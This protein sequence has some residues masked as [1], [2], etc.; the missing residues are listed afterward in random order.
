MIQNKTK[1]IGITGG[2]GTG[3]S[4]V[5]DMIREKGYPVIDADKIARQVVEKGMPA[6][7]MIVKV[8][9]EEILQK[10]GEINRKALGKI[11]FNDEDQR[12]KLNN[13]V[14]SYIYDQIKYLIDKNNYIFDI[15]FLDIPLL[16]EEYDIIREG[17]ILFDE[18]WLVYTDRK[19][20]VQ[21]IIKRD[22]ISEVDAISR[23]DAQI[24]IENKKHMASEI[25]DNSGTRDELGR[26]LDMLFK[27]V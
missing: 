19:T 3:K 4:T 23:I 10:N 6:Y 27:R 17:G 7:D 26:Q 13:I 5:T 21:R 15:I 24:D 20:Q 18:I 8:F 2:I 11:V 22:K 12:F 16:F 25:L 14:H 9:G 1:L